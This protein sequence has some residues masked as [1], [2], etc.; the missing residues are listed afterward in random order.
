MSNFLHKVFAWIW[1]SSSDPTKVSLTVKGTLAVLTGALI[2]ALS[3]AHI[4]VGI[5]E[6]NSAIDA[7]ATVVSDALVLV[8]AIGGAYG[9]VLKV[10]RTATGKNPVVSPQ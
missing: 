5:P 4:N 10:I 6:V 8:G 2:P 1:Q 9:F 7:I 3:L